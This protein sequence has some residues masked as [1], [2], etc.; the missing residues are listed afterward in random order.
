MP[1]DLVRLARPKDWVK[2]VFIFMPIPF[3]LAAGAVLRPLAFAVGVAGFCLVS[4]AVYAFN[5]VLDRER[6]RV[7]AVKRHR[8]VASGRVSP[9]AALAFAAVLAGVGM[10]LCWI[11]A[12]GLA[13][14]LAAVYAAANVAYSLGGKHV[15]LLDV[16]L[17]SSG[18]LI[19][20]FLGCALVAANPSSWLLLCSSALA[21]FMAL[22]KRRADLQAGLGSEHRPSLGGYNVA[23]LDQAMGITSGLALIAYALY[24]ME[25]EVFVAGREFASL[26]FVA[27]GVLNYLRL[28]HVRKEGASPVDLITREPSLIACGAGWGLATLWSLGIP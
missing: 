9:A 12:G 21:L 17:L 25:A 5:D 8:P 13:L 3:A 20:V 4:S 23:F 2:S 11:A 26:P 1:L 6:D 10:A 7:H 14:A 16:F 27:F 28:A 18:M 22:T 19:R 15:P 24:S